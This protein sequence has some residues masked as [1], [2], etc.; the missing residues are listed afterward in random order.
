MFARSS[1]PQS[2]RSMALLGVIERRSRWS[3][4]SMNEVKPSPRVP[5]ALQKVP[6]HVVLPLTLMISRCTLHTVP[7]PL[8][9]HMPF[10]CCPV[11]KACCL[12]RPLKVAGHPSGAHQAHCPLPPATKISL[13]N[14]C[15]SRQWC[16]PDQREWRPRDQQRPCTAPQLDP[17]LFFHRS[18]HDVRSQCARSHPHCILDTLDPT[19]CA[20]PE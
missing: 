7:S 2:N 16:V 13:Q 3:L 5:R 12:S 6:E 8:A 19:L 4:S 18:L 11:K 15:L 1:Q 20:P 10:S 9:L 14:N 17:H